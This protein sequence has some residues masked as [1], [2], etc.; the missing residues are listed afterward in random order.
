MYNK[1]Q[2]YIVMG[3]M[4]L[5]GKNLSPQNNQGS[6]KD[7]F[8]RKIGRLTKSKAYLDFCEEVYGYRMYLFSMMDKEQLD[9]VFH[10]ILLS[11]GDTL[12]DLGCGSG[13]I[14]NLLVAQ[15]GCRGIGIDQLNLDGIAKCAHPVTYI[16]GNIDRLAD[17]HLA[18]TVTL[19]ID[20][21]YFSN[22][23]GALLLYLCGFSHN[24]MYLFYSQYLFEGAA[25]GSTPLHK[26][27]TKVADILNKHG[28]SYKV[29]DYSEN[30]R[31][32]YEK[33]LVA[34]KQREAE[35]A[36]EGNLDLYEGK[37]KEDTMGKHLY[38][39]GRAKRFL[40]IVE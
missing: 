2:R 9:F 11:P 8:D 26:D 1:K 13:S 28:V 6:S 15:Y 34:L 36:R 20:S 17:Y 38:A 19:S 33:S 4:I 16:N 27:H 29:I 25:T 23:L 32:L 12:L 31:R 24:R 10:S 18:P 40:Y 37:L 14:L 22:D 30:E 7:E 35:F 21:L 39:E 5:M 3:E